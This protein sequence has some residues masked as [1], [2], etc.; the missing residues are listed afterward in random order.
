M[1]G[2]DATPRD[3]EDMI[4]LHQDQDD[5]A[6]F[7]VA[8]ALPATDLYR[9]AQERGYVDGDY[10]RQHYRRRWYHPTT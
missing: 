10:W 3:V 2:Y 4:V 9:I 5:W 6:S 8:T 1:V 7:S